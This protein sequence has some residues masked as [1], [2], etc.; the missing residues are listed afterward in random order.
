MR[1]SWLSYADAVKLMGGSDDGLVTALDTALGGLLLVGTAGTSELALSLF[2]AKSEL[3]ALNRKAVRALGE[4]R[5]G[6]GRLGRSVRM[7]AAQVVL[8]VSAFFDALREAELPFRD[9]ALERER[10]LQVGL[11]TGERP[12][13]TRL[14]A[15]ADSL[16]K[17]RI[18]VVGPT[19][20]LATAEQRVREYYEWLTTSVRRYLEGLG[21]WE[22]MSE[23]DRAVVA[24]R[25]SRDV[26]VAAARIWG[27]Q[28]RRLAAEFPE[29]AF[30]VD[31]ADHEATRRE[32]S[33]GLTALEE[34]LRGL[35]AEPEDPQRIGL[36]RHYRAELDRPIVDSGDVPDGLSIP[37]LREG[38][39]DPDFRAAD[40]SAKDRIHLEEFWGRQDV[41]NDLDGFLAAFLGSPEATYRPLLVLGQPGAGKSVLTKFLAGRLPAGDF[42]VV[43]VVLRQTPA[44]DDVQR[45]IEHAIRQ[46]TGEHGN[47]AALSRGA[48]NALRVVILDGFDELLQSTGVGSSVYL[49]EV[50]RFQEREAD[51]GRPVAVVVTSRVAVADRA[52]LPPEGAVAIRLEPF[53]DEQVERWLEIWN[54]RNEAALERR[55]LKPLPA[56]AALAHRDLA[57]QPLLLL[58]LALYDADD[59]GLQRDAGSLSQPDL[60]ERLLE[61]FARREVAKERRGLGADEVTSAVRDELHRL[62]IAAVAMFHRGRQWVTQAELDADLTAL[63]GESTP[64]RDDFKAPTT[65][66]ADAVG[67]FFFVHRTRA[68]RA[69]EEL[70]AVEFLHATFGEYLVARLVTNELRAIVQ[71]AELDLP[72]ARAAEP[73]LDLLLAVLSFTPLTERI[74]VVGSLRFRLLEL[75]DDRRD[76]LRGLLVR[77]FRAVVAGAAGGPAGTY[78]P[79]PQTP[80][81]RQAMQS[82]NL[83][84]LVM[85]AGRGRT[86]AGELFGTDGDPTQAWW[87]QAVLW[88][89]Q[90]PE[91]SW[92]SLTDTVAVTRLGDRNRR[93][94]EI[95]LADASWVPAPFDPLWGSWFGD[96]GHEPPF[97]WRED[98]RLQLR[99]TSAFL[100][101]RLSGLALHAVDALEGH[102]IRPVSAGL[103]GSFALVAGGQS[104]S[105]TRALLDLWT[106][107]TDERDVE[108][109]VAAYRLCLEVARVA[110]DPQDWWNADR[111]LTLLLR[112]AAAD[113]EH[114][115]RELRLELVHVWPVLRLGRPPSE[116]LLHWAERTAG[117]DDVPPPESAP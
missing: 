103:S 14:G 55:H 116:E 87:S 111:F 30:Y 33:S 17:G 60:Y 48:G 41:Q 62:S 29:L 13:G 21:V 78:A 81:G 98:A 94:L 91:E 42:V 9:D 79:V 70:T 43:R 45:Q 115:P 6:L 2:D 46:A 36:V 101:D 54:G 3:T 18:P 40:V 95:A 16:L 93:D 102:G 104:L 88:Y 20:T 69:G 5:D 109:L 52:L 117:P 82:L 15:V 72:G 19:T 59:N 107:S 96:L 4:R 8:V 35:L 11:A 83:V 77:A 97:G 27:D 76:R 66:G 89:S 84:L 85:L 25:M 22:A 63:L 53:R 38:Y 56:A 57:G 61:R 23:T 105:A 32:V 39:V 71:V 31:R 90:C 74:T 68:E 50:A 100:A 10:A 113:R 26:P 108:R 1:N 12:S 106:A 58:M 75:P 47:W 112:Q 44:D 80:A 37:T 7:E 73:N 114:L 92:W 34:R 67:R 99:R 65:P 49:R 110:F 64:G 24:E 51:Q 28:F 86:T